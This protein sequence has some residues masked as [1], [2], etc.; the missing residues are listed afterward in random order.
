M[1]LKLKWS[2]GTNLNAY[3]APFI[4]LNLVGNVRFRQ[5]CFI[6]VILKDLRPTESGGKQHILCLPLL[7]CYRGISVWKE[8]LKSAYS[9]LS[10]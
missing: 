4:T 8:G 5:H 2:S 1:F 9:E 3:N 10:N 7:F 6:T